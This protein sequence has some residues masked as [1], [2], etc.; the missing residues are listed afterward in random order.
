MQNEPGGAYYTAERSFMPLVCYES[1]KE[2][3]DCFFMAALP[4]CCLS[5]WHCTSDSLL[6]LSQISAKVH[7]HVNWD[8][9]HLSHIFHPLNT[10]YGCVR[11]GIT[12][13]LHQLTFFSPSLSTPNE[14]GYSLTL[15]KWT[16]GHLTSTEP[17]LLPAPHI[18]WANDNGKRALMRVVLTSCRIFN[19]V[20][21]LGQNP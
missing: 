20:C 19:R 1:V 7:E 12:S 9:T 5:A 8:L 11:E 10:L 13:A 16:A 6:M 4:V 3:R 14:H 15:D 2:Y 17:H 21:Y 18:N